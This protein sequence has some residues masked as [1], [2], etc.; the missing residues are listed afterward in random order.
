MY[1]PMLISIQGVVFDTKIGLRRGITHM[2][3]WELLGL[4]VDVGIGSIVRVEIDRGNR[5]AGEPLAI[6]CG[7]EGNLVDNRDLIFK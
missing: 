6:S 1:C 5:A 3:P 7:C 2:V 4:D